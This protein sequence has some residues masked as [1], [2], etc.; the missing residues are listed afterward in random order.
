MQAQYVAWDIMQRQAEAKAAGKTAVVAKIEQEKS[1]YQK[2]VNNELRKQP[3]DKNDQGNDLSNS[4]YGILGGVGVVGCGGG[5]A[6]GVLGVGGQI[7]AADAAPGRGVAV[8]SGITDGG[9][10]SMTVA[11]LEFVYHDEHGGVAVAAGSQ[12]PSRRLTGGSRG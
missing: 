6:Q 1:E 11:G 2:L 5:D 12:S 7:L 4:Q 9:K 10:P 8:Q 3:P